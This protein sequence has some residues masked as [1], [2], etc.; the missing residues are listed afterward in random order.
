MEWYY[1]EGTEQKG[2]VSEKDIKEMFKSGRIT[3]ETLVW[4]E[5]MEKWAEL[6]S[7][8][9]QKPEPVIVPPHKPD[10]A[11]SPKV[12]VLDTE[13]EQV[14]PQQGEL[15]RCSEC[16]MEFPED[17]VISYDGAVICASCKPVFMQKLKEGIQ[18][19]GTLSYAGF[20][21]RFLAKMVDWIILMVAQTVI[22]APIL[23]LMGN[24]GREGVEEGMG[25]MSIFMGLGFFIQMIIPL[26][27][28]TWFVGKYAATPGKMVCKLKIIRSDQT[29]VSYGRAL[30]RSFAEWISGTIFAVGYLIAV[31]D[32]QKRTLHD[33]ICDTLVV[34][35]D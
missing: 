14:S 35:K 23:F 9:K 26:V 5:G 30:G 13:Y 32:D 25:I 19:A 10:I 8:V 27:Y 18:V 3:M 1:A 34:H 4:R 20:W 22:I 29:L 6:G 12:K 17:E 11:L 31:F 15:F 2:P 16:G 33:R 28:T 21:P 24:K 7:I